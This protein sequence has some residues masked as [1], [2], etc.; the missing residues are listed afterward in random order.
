VYLRVHV[1]RFSICGGMIATGFFCMISTLAKPERKVFLSQRA[2]VHLLAALEFISLS[3]QHTHTFA[4]HRQGVNI[5]FLIIFRIGKDSDYS[6]HINA[7]G[8]ENMFRKK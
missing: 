6:E 3:E 8:Y 1:I 4:E 7:S 5:F 2:F